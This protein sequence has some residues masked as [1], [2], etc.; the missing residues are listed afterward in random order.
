M[1]AADVPPRRWIGLL[2]IAAFIAAWQL[3]AVRIGDA[4]TLATPFAV[5]SGFVSML[6]EPFA[7]STL[8]GHLLASLGRFGSG[9]GL[10][11]AVG[12]PL[13]LSMGW[14]KG[15]DAA[16]QPAFNVLRFIAPIAWVPFAVLWFGTGFGGPVLIIFAGAFPAC[17]IGAYGGA[18]LVDVKLLEAARM[19]GARN[20]R[21]LLEVILPSAM[22]AVVSALRVA[23]GNAWQSLVGAELIVA[24]SGVAYIMVRGQMNR[25]IVIVLVG[26]LAIGLVGLLLDWLFRRF[27]RFVQRRLGAVA[28]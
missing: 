6:H 7:G 1:I 11:V 9:F 19:L 13:G 25:T 28:G 24:A 26:M 20:L 10:S 22:P 18:R 5:L 12:I 21:I 23:A 16:V 4:S 14:F 27:E 2:G 17:V 3:A 15:L 8:Q